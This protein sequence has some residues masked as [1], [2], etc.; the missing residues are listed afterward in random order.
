VAGD[1]V[2]Q[3]PGRFVVLTEP[4]PRG[5]R[6]IVPEVGCTDRGRDYACASWG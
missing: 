1:L 6:V 5:E 4:E 2:V 3:A